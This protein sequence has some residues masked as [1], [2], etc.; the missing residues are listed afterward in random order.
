[1][2]SKTMSRKLRNLDHLDLAHAAT[3]RLR[4][5]LRSVFQGAAADPGPRPARAIAPAKARREMERLARIVDLADKAERGEVKVTRLTGLSKEE[6]RQ[7]LFGR[8]PEA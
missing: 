4:L 7:R 3:V 8:M 1:M 2:K 6:R 5:G